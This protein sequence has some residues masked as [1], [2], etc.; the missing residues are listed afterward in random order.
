MNSTLLP[1]EEENEEHIPFLLDPLSVIIKL[2]ILANKPIGTKLL[3]KNNVI[4]FQEP[5]AF[6]SL[7]RTLYK[8]SKNDL[9]YIYNPIYLGC[10]HFLSKEF[11][12]KCGRIVK[13]FECAKCG[14][15]NLM[16]TYKKN[17]LICLTLNYY[18]AII[19]NNTNGQSHLTNDNIFREDSL[20]KYYTEDLV[21]KFNEQWTDNKIKVVLDLIHFV[22]DNDGEHN[23]GSLE[24]IMIDID[25][26]C[27]EIAR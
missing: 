20:T 11:V 12:G 26:L 4:H 15:Q 16:E 6:Q 21:E 3:I 23:V 8:T 27:K 22:S 2:A 24:N 10:V 18:Y 17:P 19:A 14:L 5:G 13:L 25:K 7:C 1:T 9:Q